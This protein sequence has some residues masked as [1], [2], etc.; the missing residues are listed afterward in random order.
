VPTRT[1][2]TLTCTGKISRNAAEFHLR[3]CV[4]GEFLVR[5]SETTKGSY[6]VSVVHRG[7]I[8]HYRI[9]TDG[10]E[11]SATALHR[12]K[13]LAQLVEHYKTDVSMGCLLLKPVPKGR[14]EPLGVADG[15]GWV[16]ADTRWEIGTTLYPSHACVCTQNTHMCTPRSSR[17]T[18]TATTT[19]AATIFHQN[20]R[21]PPTFHVHRSNHTLTCPCACFPPHTTTRTFNPPLRCSLSSNRS[22]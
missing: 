6:T 8:L 14:V 21:Q 4:E 9:S 16:G 19:T 12:F 18:T 22:R 11:F 17:S 2:R 13:S 10:G 3:R 7:E 20:H 15:G 5:E 1:R